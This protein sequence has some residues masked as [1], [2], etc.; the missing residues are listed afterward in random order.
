MSARDEPKLGAQGAPKTAHNAQETLRSSRGLRV[1]GGVFSVACLAGAIVVALREQ[2]AMT[3]AIDS[4]RSASFSEI[5][6][7]LASVALG[8]VLTSMLFSILVRRY[9][10]VAWHEM[11]A[12]IAATSLANML[13]LKPGFVARVAWHRARHGIRARDSLRTILEAIGLSALVAG[14]MLGAVVLLRAISMPVGFALLAPALFGITAFTQRGRIFGQALL[15]RNAEFALAVLRYHLAL[16]LVGAETSLETSIV[17][18][19]AS[20]VATLVPFVSNGLGVREWVTALLLPALS[21]GTFA[22]GVAAELVLRVAEL[23]IT[24]PAGLCASAWLVRVARV[25]PTKATSA[26]S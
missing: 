9:A 20:A 26:S 1:L 21:G 19:C 5:L 25:T 16:S 13:P 17:L 23:A 8:I 11:L 4:L 18:A 12:L 14:A 10:I 22:A 7:L 2:S 3:A 6:L 24:L 15:V